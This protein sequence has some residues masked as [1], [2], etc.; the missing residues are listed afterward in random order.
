MLMSLGSVY[1]N[2]DID[3]GREDKK[4]RKAWCLICTLPLSN[5]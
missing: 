2:K 3:K 1:I 5:A 4:R